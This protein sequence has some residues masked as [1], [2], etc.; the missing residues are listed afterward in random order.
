MARAAALRAAGQELADAGLDAD[1]FWEKIT[2]QPGGV[3]V[4]KQN[5]KLPPLILLI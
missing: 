5:L 2:S 4:E 3:N 1:T